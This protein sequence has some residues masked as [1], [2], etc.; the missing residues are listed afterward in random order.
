M[1]L[2][3]ELNSMLDETADR[4]LQTSCGEGWL[5]QPCIANMS[6]LEYRVYMLGG[7]SPVSLSCVLSIQS[8]LGTAYI[9]L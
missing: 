5:V 8:V 3:P 9:F 4:L 7:A 2:T 6:G 1:N